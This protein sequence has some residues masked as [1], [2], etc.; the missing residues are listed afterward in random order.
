MPRAPET[1]RRR[2]WIAAAALIAVGIVVLVALIVLLARG[3]QDA[4][5]GPGATPSAGPEPE[6]DSSASA[7]EP[8]PRADPAQDA[9]LQAAESH[10]ANKEYT[11]AVSVVEAALRDHPDAFR[12]RRA[13]RVLHACAQMPPSADAAFA[14]LE[15]PMGY[16]GADVMFSLMVNTRIHPA[17]RARAERWLAKHWENRASPALAVAYQ[18]LLAKT[19]AERRAQLEPAREVGDTRALPYLEQL[20]TANTCGLRDDDELAGAIRSIERRYGKQR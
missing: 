11:R 20:R 18:L 2:R 8:A 10:V 1:S 15:G 12:D 9:A 3:R 19:C 7:D 16:R 14:L 6:P 13:S 17:T 5:G 4:A